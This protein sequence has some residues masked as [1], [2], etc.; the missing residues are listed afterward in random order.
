MD[1]DSTGRYLIATSPFKS[2]QAQTNYPP[3]PGQP[4]GPTY[5]GT[6]SVFDLD[7]ATISI[8]ITPSSEPANPTTLTSANFAFTASDEV[9]TVRCQLDGGP[10]GLCTSATSQTYSGLSSGGHTFTVQATDS[11]GNT[12]SA[13]YAWTVGSGGGGGGGGPTNS[14]PPSI[15]G[16]P[17]EAQMLSA[18]PGTWSGTPSFTYQWQDCKGTTC[19]PITGATASTYTLLSADVGSSVDVVVT[20]AITGASTTATSASTA[21][22]TSAP[23]P[24]TPVLDNFNRANNTGPPG[25]SW[26][27]FPDFD[28]NS[29]NTLLISG[30]ELTGDP[31]ENAD[32]WNAQTFGPNS[33][34]YVT[35]VAKPTVNNDIVVLGLRYQSPGTPGASS[36]YQ[37][38]FINE[39]SGTDQYQILLRTNGASTSTTLASVTG[40]E[41][42]AGDELLFR[43]IGTTLELWRNS[44]GTWTKILSATNGTISGGG[45]LAL[46]ARDNAVRL[47][48]FGGGTLP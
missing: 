22:V 16:S 4:G 20:A 24:L 13:S 33:E 12:A 48:N 31:G 44:A 25:P 6:T 8:A 10:L 5:T 35:V 14:Q 47:D 9:A 26:S 45:Y 29:S 43:A 36:G 21:V 38:R 3:F 23:G 34:V 42:V 32:Y 19:T 17:V 7:P 18:N 30:Q 37:A 1:V 11:A 40:P 41:L 15:S 27:A 46:I 2:T 39:A 28:T